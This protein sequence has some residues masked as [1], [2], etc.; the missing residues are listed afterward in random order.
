MIADARSLAEGAMMETDLCIVGAG[1]AGITLAQAFDSHRWSVCLV[2]SGGLRLERKTQK[3]YEAEN[4]GLPYF[5]LDA[6]RQRS[7]GGTTNLWG[8]WRRPMDEIDFEHRS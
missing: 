8:G 7:F 5:P 4:V 2:E 6:N 1:V 3:L